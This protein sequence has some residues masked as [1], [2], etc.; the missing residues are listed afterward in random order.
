MEIDFRID[1][2]LLYG[3]AHGKH[4]GAQIR[5]SI[6]GRGIYS[7]EDYYDFFN[8]VVC[9]DCEFDYVLQNFHKYL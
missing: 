5:C 6:C 8:E 2:W 4:D 9:S 7:G 1:N 3:H